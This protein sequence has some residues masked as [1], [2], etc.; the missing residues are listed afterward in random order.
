[1]KDNIMTTTTM[2]AYDENGQTYLEVWNN[3]NGEC[4]LYIGDGQN[5]PYYSGIIAIDKA[6]LKALVDFLKVE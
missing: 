4:V 3:E 6:A 2:K 5:D 1:M